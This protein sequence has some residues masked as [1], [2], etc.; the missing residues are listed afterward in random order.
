M[1][2]VPNSGDVWK[3]VDPRVER[4]VRIITVNAPAVTLRKCDA[5][6]HVLASRTTTANIARFSGKRG[7]YALHAKAQS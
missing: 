7:G 2:D 6:G 3:E 4:Y 1:S 5:S